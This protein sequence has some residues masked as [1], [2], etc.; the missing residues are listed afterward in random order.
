[1]LAQAVRMY[2][3]FHSLKLITLWSF[4]GLQF[5]WYLCRCMCICDSKVINVQKF[6]N[7]IIPIDIMYFD[8]TSSNV[9]GT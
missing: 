1:M 3:A 5:K 6:L 7:R 8:V 4:A 2:I 9:L